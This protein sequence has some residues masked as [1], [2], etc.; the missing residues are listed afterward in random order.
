MNKNLFFYETSIGKI[1]I[2]DNGTAI[3]N[4]YFND[5][6]I[7]RNVHIEETTLIKKAATELYEYLRGTRQF[8]DLLLAPEGT[9]FQQAVWRSLQEIPYG[10]TRCYQ[11][12]AE[13]INRPKACRA[14]GLANNK[15]P[16]AIII[17]CHRVIGKNGQ[18][19]GYAGGISMKERLLEIE[20]RRVK[21]REV[22]DE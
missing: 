21:N 4:L 11:E 9:E 5:E 12:I 18:L 7:E 6:A 13:K 16:I 2:A 1:G 22:D 10:E 20:R 8:F 3:T 17:P 14:V 15:N 19:V